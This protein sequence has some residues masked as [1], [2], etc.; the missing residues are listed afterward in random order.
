MHPTVIS[1]K[2]GTCP[3]CGMDL[4]R[5][6]RPGEEVKITEDLASLIKS[7]NE[8]VVTSIKT[9][10]GEFKTMPVSIEAQGIVTYDTR[11]IYTIPARIGGRLEKVFLKYAFQPVRKGQKVVEIYSPE[12]LT[13]QRELLYLIE[14][15]PGNTSII[16][17]AKNKLYLLGATQSQVAE[18]IRRKDIS[19]TFSVY[20]PYDGYVIY[21]GQQAPAITTT[22]SSASSST[23]GGGMGG[24]SASV[25]SSSS[26]SGNTSSSELIR[27]GSYVSTGQT[28]FKVVNASALRVE[29]DLSSAQTGRLNL[30]DE[31]DLDLGNKKTVKGKVDFVQ[32]FFTE[33]EEFVKVRVYLKN[34]EELQ[35]GQL[36]R[37]TI[38]LKAVEA[39]WVPREAVFDLGL[40]KIV[41]VKE[42][43]VFKPRNVKAGV[44]T[45]GLVQI[46]QGLSSS[47]EVASNAQY[48][49]DSESFIKTK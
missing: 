10:K 2:Q 17:S 16:E 39:L 27:E 43:G 35:I 24:S 21:E 47:D 19:S 23:M 20:S 13:A 9:I 25:P 46:I 7:P 34:S 42:R 15:D 14:N 38:Q 22:S 3:V 5:K 37:A 8:V 28:L 36:V 12:L 32:P 48:L 4:V 29:L 11:N 45:E 44:R 18:V 49:V 41:F 1:D 31:V 6:V 26:T 40:D 33:G 30:N